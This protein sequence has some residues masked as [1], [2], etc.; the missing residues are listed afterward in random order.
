MSADRSTHTLPPTSER[1]R[2][3]AEIAAL[4]RRLA[5]AEQALASTSAV[6]HEMQASPVKPLVVHGDLMAFRRA[7]LSLMEDADQA[8]RQAEETAAKLA[9]SEALLKLFVEHAPA[10]LAMLDNDL[11]YIAVSR[12]WLDDYGLGERDIAGLPHY[13]VFPEIPEHWK[14][15]HRRAL[16]GEVIT[17][18][19]DRFERLDGTVSWLRWEVRP[20]H[21]QDGS[22]GGIVI[23]SE[24][25][26]ERKQS[27]NVM[28]ESL[29]RD[30][31]RADELKTIF[32][33]AP[34]G[35]SLCLDPQGLHIQGNKANEDIFGIVPGGELSMAAAHPPG[36][37]V[38]EQG[39]EV[40]VCDLPMQRAVRGAKIDEQIL[41]VI[42][43]DGRSVTVLAKAMPLFD[44]SG[45]PRGAVGA[46]MDITAL[47]QAQDALHES[48]ERLRLALRAGNAGVWE[49][50]VASD[51]LVWSPENYALYGLSQE[52]RP[53]RFGDWAACVHPD[54]LGPT[55]AAVQ[56]TLSGQVPEFR[57]EFRVVLPDGRLR[58][59]LGLG[60]VE[61]TADGTPL[62][63]TGI[64]LDMTEHKLAEMAVRE[65]ESF[66]R[67]TLESIPGMVF[68]T[69]P[70]GYCDYQSQQWVDYTGVP[71]AEHLGVGW[72]KLLHPDD[73][74]RALAASREALE[75]GTAYDLEY[76]VRRHD[77]AYEWFRVIGRPIH[78]EQ[79]RIVRWFGV[80]L[81]IDSLKQAEEKL[82]QSEERFRQIFEHAASGIAITDWN[83]R[84]LQGNPAYCTLLGYSAEELCRLDFPTLIHP[85]DREANLKEI[86]RLKNGEVPYFDIENRYVRKDGEAVWVRKFVSLLREE[87]G[88]PTHLLAL[89]TDNTERRRMEQTLR[90][91]D[92]RKDEFLATLAHELRNPLAPLANALQVLNLAQ[93]DAAVTQRFREMMERQ[94]QHLVRLVDDLLEVSRISRGKIKLAKAPVDLETVIRN[95]METSQPLID[96]AEHSLTLTLS[97]EP[98]V[99]DA[100]PVRLAQV[101]AN[102]LNNAAKYMERGG[103]IE[104]SSKREGRSAVVCVRDHGIGIA[105]DDLPH[106]FELFTQMERGRGRHQG[107]LGIGLALARSLVELHGGQISARSAGLD[108]GSEFIVR[109]PLAETGLQSENPARGESEALARH[110]I[111]V[112]DDNQDAADS[113]AELLHLRG[114]RIQVVYDGPAALRAV[115]FFQPTAVILDLGMP[116]MD[117]YEVARRLRQHPRYKHIQL[118]ALTGWGQEAD[119]RRSQAAGLDHHLVKPVSI[120]SLQNLLVS[121]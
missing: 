1:D 46:F 29:S 101:F 105:A 65:S 28:R 89:V 88:T 117:G 19:E 121:L 47:R 77:G 82:R 52:Q 99:L 36:F 44:E 73:R 87:S 56:D 10:A 111:L 24:D 100:D 48:E 39:R 3:L 18:D 51:A 31:Q 8:R 81:N 72:T 25:I 13:E 34:I 116:D 115:D 27:E 4:R 23:F 40:A 74:A 103:R 78:D 95:A 57:A 90:D 43:R 118:I 11:R 33:T 104:L 68:T 21:I 60:H 30:R 67:Q 9:E 110:R 119:R 14:K 69:R 84:F 83:G 15:V 98:L 7:A 17:A 109:L 54:D 50:E 2:L 62:R 70:D 20:W 6:E 80:A 75:G 26:T 93:D 16:A 45:Q 76:R 91:A 97:P 106:V 63:M 71:M 12:R 41:D 94:V 120:D 59:L 79:G 66:H 53:L 92:R 5:E 108:R 64:N 112:V 96:A 113:L 22:I 35:L 61:R 37:R 38:F 49:W 32:D 55:K 107:G 86:Q 114:A 85:D 102:L 58:W 42:R